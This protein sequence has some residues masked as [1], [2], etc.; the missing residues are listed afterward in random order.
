MQVIGLCDI[1][2]KNSSK[3]VL[4]ITPV[5]TIRHFLAEFDYW[6]PIQ[7]DKNFTAR[8]FNVYIITD[9]ERSLQQRCKIL[10]QWCLNGGVLI[11]GYE[12]LRLFIAPRKRPRN[13]N[14]AEEAMHH[15]IKSSLISSNLVVCDEGHRIKHMDTQ[16]FQTLQQLD[17]K[18]RI[19]LTGY[20][21]QN[22]LHEYFTL[23]H[24]VVPN[25][26]G[27]ECEFKDIFEK[28]II[29]GQY[30]DSSPAEVQLMK[31]RSH[32]LQSLMGPFVHRRCENIL[33]ES[34]PQKNEYTLFFK[35]TSLQKELY[36]KVLELTT[37]NP[38][39]A[40]SIICKIMNDPYILFDY[41]QNDKATEID[42]ED[43]DKENV[44]DHKDLRLIVGGYV[45]ELIES[46]PKM[47][48]LFQMI[49]NAL[50]LNEKMIIFSQSLLTLNMIERC[51]QIKL[52]WKRN[53]HFYSK[54]QTISTF[55]I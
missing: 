46:S 9:S 8:N 44:M 19:V 28:P 12:M 17:T 25:F 32:V 7:P 13:E 23:I 20:P 15:T 43:E 21:L 36:E 39:N 18:L 41:L 6:L 1:F 5:N 53:L 33:R 42:I 10:T 3:T 47:I 31:Y 40:F 51:L 45:P 34:L 54:E 11:L 49:D 35:M 29:M 4:I 48:A 14:G 38:V 55:N 50:Q 26:L 2:L 52:K 16:M 27:N 24:F 22:N 37:N 30:S